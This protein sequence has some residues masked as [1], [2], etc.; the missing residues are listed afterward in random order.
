MAAGAETLAD[1]RVGGRESLVD[2]AEGDVVVAQHVIAPLRVHQ[3]RPGLERCK[4][5]NHRR[6]RF[7][8]DVDQSRRVFGDIAII[9]DHGGDPIAAIAHS[10]LRQRIPLAVL[11]RRFFCLSGLACSVFARRLMSAPVNTI[12]TPGNARAALTSRRRIR[13]CA[14]GLRRIAISSIPGTFMPLT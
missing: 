2:I 7:E 8:I 3:R 9:G 4:R 12:C 5:I 1:N 10:V 6:Q 11:A 14:S 13:A